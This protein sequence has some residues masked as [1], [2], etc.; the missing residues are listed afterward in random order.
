MVI[1]PQPHSRQQLAFNSTQIL[2]PLQVVQNLAFALAASPGALCVSRRA[3]RTSRRA[4]TDC[5]PAS[6]LTMLP[7][8]LH[9]ATLFAGAAFRQLVLVN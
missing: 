5:A 7:P 9:L 1:T 8:W 3:L 2:F 4:A 6:L